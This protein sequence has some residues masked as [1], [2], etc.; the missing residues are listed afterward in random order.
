MDRRT[1]STARACPALGKAQA[2]DDTGPGGGDGKVQRY[3][4]VIMLGERCVHCGYC[5]GFCERGA[6]VRPSRLGPVLFLEGLCE[7][8]GRCVDAC[9]YRAIVLPST[10]S[11]SPLA[12]KRST[13]EGRGQGGLTQQDPGS[14]QQDPGRRLGGGKDPEATTGKG[15]RVGSEGQ[16]GETTSFSRWFPWN[17]LKVP[18]LSRAPETHSGKTRAVRWQNER[19]TGQR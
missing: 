2:G 6:L 10:P 16:D 11:G 7:G 19:A 17:N 14:T 13:R 1:C 4:Q 15:P 5:L 9:P 3:A 18:A 8:C 12:G